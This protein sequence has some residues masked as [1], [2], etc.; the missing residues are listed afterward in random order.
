MQRKKFDFL[1][2][3]CNEL[4]SVFLWW[5]VFAIFELYSCNRYFCIDIILLIYLE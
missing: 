4:Q 5:T 3:L 1:V 2:S